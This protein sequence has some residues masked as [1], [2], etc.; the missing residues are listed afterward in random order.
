[1]G[2]KHIIWTH[3]GS[4]A[5]NEHTHRTSNNPTAVTP[6][7]LPIQPPSHVKDRAVFKSVTPSMFFSVLKAVPGHLSWLVQR[8]PVSKAVRGRTQRGELVTGLNSSVTG[9]SGPKFLSFWHKTVRIRKCNAVQWPACVQ[10]LP[11]CSSVI[12]EW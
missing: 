9:F 10:F 5:S 11:S 4:H 7:F 6:A 3:A 2:G 12:M 1:M 8:E